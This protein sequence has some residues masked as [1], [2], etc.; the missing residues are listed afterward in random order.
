MFRLDDWLFWWK[1]QWLTNP[2]SSLPIKLIAGSF[3]PCYIICQGLSPNCFFFKAK[4]MDD[5]T[6]S[7]NTQVAQERSLA[8][9]YVVRRVVMTF[10]RWRDPLKGNRLSIYLIFSSTNKSI[11][12]KTPIFALWPQANDTSFTFLKCFLFEIIDCELVLLVLCLFIYVVIVDPME[13]QTYYEG[14]RVF[15]RDNIIFLARMERFS[16]SPEEIREAFD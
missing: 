3:A 5:K 11:R 10:T 8:S 7:L 4:K 13:L 1:D 6:S 9:E 15:T 12:Y 14:S 16:S 2:Q